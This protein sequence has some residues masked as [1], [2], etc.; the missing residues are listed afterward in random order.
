MTSNSF[1]IPREF[2]EII[3]VYPIRAVH[4]FQSYSVC[5]L[6]QHSSGVSLNFHVYDGMKTWR[7]VFMHYAI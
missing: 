4:I 2:G 3:L 5:K 1:E 7:Q 6:C